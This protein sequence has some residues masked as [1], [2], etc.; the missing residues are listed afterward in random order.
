MTNTLCELIEKCKTT[1]NYIS[2]KDF[3]VEPLLLETYKGFMIFSEETYTDSEIKEFKNGNK[4]NKYKYKHRYYALYKISNNDNKENK[5]LTFILYNP[6][7]ANPENIDET[8]A[9]CIEL[10]KKKSCSNVEIINLFSLRQ[11]ESSKQDLENTNSTN[12]EFLNEYIKILGNDI[13]AAWG[14]GKDNKHKEYCEEIYDCLKS[15]NAFFI[16]IDVKEINQQIN[17][18][19]DKRVWN[20]IGGFNNIATLVPIEK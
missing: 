11:T 14:C 4:F 20:G 16:G 5:S 18:H 15:K 8:I 19:P 9:N 6:S 2:T 17:R 12:K 10:A 3:I 1:K 7:Y 13:V